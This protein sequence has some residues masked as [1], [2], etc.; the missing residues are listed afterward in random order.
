MLANL[1]LHYIYLECFIADKTEAEL[2]NGHEQQDQ[3]EKQNQYEGNQPKETNDHKHNGDHFYA[4][5][6][7]KCKETL[8]NSSF[9]FGD[10]IQLQSATDLNKEAEKN[11]MLP[12]FVLF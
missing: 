6:D 3:I 12:I 4:I 8:Q 1:H 5:P 10:A 9:I 7:P 11:S 2:G